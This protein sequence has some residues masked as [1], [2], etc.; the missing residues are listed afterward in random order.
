[1]THPGSAIY[2][3]MLREVKEEFHLGA[4][5][6]CDPAG[7]INDDSTEVGK[8]HF[9]LLYLLRVSSPDMS[10]AEEGKHTGQWA[11]LAELQSHYERM[12]TWSQIAMDHVLRRA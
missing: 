7:V 5:F 10:V 9:G 1:M 4:T 8:V 3:E 12:E 2:F 6:S 11:T